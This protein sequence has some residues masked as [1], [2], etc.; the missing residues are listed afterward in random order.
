MKEHRLEQNQVI[1]I[2]DHF[3]VA[4]DANSRFRLYNKGIKIEKMFEF[5]SSVKNLQ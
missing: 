4:A 2:I 1:K 5:S 3:C